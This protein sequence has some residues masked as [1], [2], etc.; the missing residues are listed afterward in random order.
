MKRVEGTVGG[1]ER[2]IN[3]EIEIN[4]GI[5]GGLLTL[6]QTKHLHVGLLLTVLFSVSRVARAPR[7]P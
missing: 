2:I 5:N 3:T 1:W 4:K 7:D 6:R